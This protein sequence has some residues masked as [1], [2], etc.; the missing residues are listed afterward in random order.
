VALPVALAGLTVAACGGGDD[1][2]LRVLVWAGDRELATEQR[3]ADFFERQH[4]GLRVTVE[5][6]PTH[7][8]EK[9]LTSI[10][11]GTPPAVFLL[12]GPDIP[13]FLD[14]GLTLD[15]TPYLGKVG[16]EPDRVL[17]EVLETF[18]RGGRLYA[19]PKDYTPMVIY[20]NRTVFERF[21]V[22]LPPDTGWTRA[23]FL[24]AARA[25]T[26]D[27]TGDGR[28]DVYA[29]DFPRNPYQ[30]IPWVWAGGGDI[31]GP[32]GHRA[33][34]ALDAPATIESL[35]FLTDLVTEARVTPGVQFI[36]GGDPAREARFATGGQ[37]MLYSGHWTLQLLTS[38]M[39]ARLDEIAVAPIPH[40]PG[41]GPVTVLYA[42]GWAVPANVEHK[43]LAIELAAFLA[44]EEAQRIRA[45][46][47]LA[48]PAFR[49]L[50]E[51]VAEADPYGLEAAFLRE[52]RRG[53]MTWGAR[54]RDFHEVEEA[55]FQVMDRHLLRG[56]PLD[57][58]TTE[59]AGRIDR[60][61]E[62]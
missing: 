59:V 21:D 39:R 15:L 9:L 2:R 24:D 58:V 49:D 4:P 47:R 30:W 17:P 29:L 23:E 42:S 1:L 12:D 6:T 52:A 31:L 16:Y 62:R 7:Y 27:T 14:R 55:L 19:L 60:I 36:E 48:V 22:A 38:S 53:R 34:G 32:H 18:R 50:A 54:V 46:T 28:T 10:A 11:A 51:E 43:R 8:Q 45:G 57:E 33:S 3:I 20:L 5:S 61:L 41:E 37:A 44:S 56:E 13:T 25:L 35:D 40:V 26:R